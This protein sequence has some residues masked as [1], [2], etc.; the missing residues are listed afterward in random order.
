MNEFDAT[1]TTTASRV[2]LETRRERRDEKTRAFVRSRARSTI[3]RRARSAVARSSPR[4]DDRR[5]GGHVTRWLKTVTVRV[6]KQ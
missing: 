1:T 4:D 6:G 3:S 5:D 2:V